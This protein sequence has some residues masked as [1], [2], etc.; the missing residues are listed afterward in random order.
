ME[1]S[2]GYCTSRSW[3]LLR[4]GLDHLGTIMQES[5]GAIQ[6]K[7]LCLESKMPVVDI[8]PAIERPGCLG[9]ARNR[10]HVELSMGPAR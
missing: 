4:S 8:T 1:D 7:N 3:S 10:Y 2:K 5:N 9:C 6:G